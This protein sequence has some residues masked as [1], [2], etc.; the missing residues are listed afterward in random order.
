MSIISDNSLERDGKAKDVLW[1][2]GVLDGRETEQTYDFLFWCSS[3]IVLINISG[4]N[5]GGGGECI[6]P[7]SFMVPE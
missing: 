5:G 6:L 7:L 2:I 3:F 1:L 4:C